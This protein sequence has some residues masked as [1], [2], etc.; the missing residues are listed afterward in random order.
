M[1]AFTPQHYRIGA[2]RWTVRRRVGSRR[3]RYKTA[4]VASPN[5]SSYPD[6]LVYETFE[7]DFRIEIDT[8]ALVNW[9]V[10]R[11]R[12]TK[13]GRSVIQGGMVVCK[14]MRCL[15]VDERSEPIALPDCYEPVDD[16]P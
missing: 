10:K 2:Y 7:A 5:G 4:G 14:R 3:V 11:A 13:S 9:L 16:G 12:D 8:A 15:K 1:S 6:R